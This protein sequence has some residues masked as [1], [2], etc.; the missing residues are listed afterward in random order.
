M[1]EIEFVETMGYLTKYD[2]GDIM[3][4]DESKLD[5]FLGDDYK[6]I[7]QERKYRV[8]NK[9]FSGWYMPERILIRQKYPLLHRAITHAQPIGL[10]FE[11]KWK[12]HM[13]YIQSAPMRSMAW[14]WLSDEEKVNY[15]QMWFDSAGSYCTE[16]TLNKGEQADLP[17]EYYDDMH[18]SYSYL[19]SYKASLEEVFD[20]LYVYT[21]KYL[22]LTDAQRKLDSDMDR[23]GTYNTP[24]GL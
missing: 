21:D 10:V 3:Y 7:A 4:L 22:N 6:A 8:L 19:I 12:Q 11:D 20:P 1:T 2:D 9:V 15:K 18:L 23:L 24:T 13:K 16:M 14:E 17:D 5:N